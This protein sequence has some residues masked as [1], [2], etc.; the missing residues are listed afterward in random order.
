MTLNS[1]V[2]PKPTTA[3]KHDAFF[4]GV[5]ARNLNLNVV[6]FWILLST[7]H[8]T[9]RRNEEQKSVSCTCMIIAGD[10]SNT[11]PVH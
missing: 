10:C 3:V 6:F 4:L 5:R 9:F 7:I 11:F 1:E 2:Q 8:H